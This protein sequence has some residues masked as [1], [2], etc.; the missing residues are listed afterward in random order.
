VAGI[1]QRNRK[2][3]TNMSPWVT[4]EAI[5]KEYDGVVWMNGLTALL[6]TPN[7]NIAIGAGI[8][9]LLDGNRTYWIYQ[10]QPWIGFAVGIDLN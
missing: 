8:D 2:G 5:G 6:A 7:L 4:R 10:N 9:Y 3:A 1:K